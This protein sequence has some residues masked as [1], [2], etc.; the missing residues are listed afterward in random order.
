MTSSAISESTKVS[1]ILSK[2]S[3]WWDWYNQVEGL[4]RER[5]VSEYVN[6]DTHVDAPVPPPQP[7]PV[8]MRIE[9]VTT[10]QQVAE[11]NFSIPWNE[12]IRVYNDKKS[13]ESSLPS[14]LVIVKWTKP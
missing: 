8:N 9:G 11:L 4:A 5:S 13:L 6:P 12:E 10:L 1:I 7:H 2:P 3:D 14:R